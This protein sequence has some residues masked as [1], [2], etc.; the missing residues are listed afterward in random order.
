MIIIIE[1]V[2]EFVC[3]NFLE[4]SKKLGIVDMKVVMHAHCDSRALM[5][6]N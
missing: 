6:T 1:E 3:T 2:F 4:D 5:S